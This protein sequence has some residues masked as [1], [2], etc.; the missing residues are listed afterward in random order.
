MSDKSSFLVTASMA[1]G[2]LALGISYFGN[3]HKNSSGSV[4]NPIASTGQSNTGLDETNESP[5]TDRRHQCQRGRL[6]W[7][8]RS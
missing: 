8:D 7:L 1:I 6:G 3:Q 2:T 4:Y 5:A